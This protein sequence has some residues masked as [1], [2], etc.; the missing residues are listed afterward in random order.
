MMQLFVSD[1]SFLQHLQQD[2][3]QRGTV[4]FYLDG[5]Q[6]DNKDDLLKEIATVTQFPEDF[7]SNWDALYD[8]LTD[9]S[10]CDASEYLFIYDNAQILAHA[11]PEDWHTFCAILRDTVTYWQD[12]ATPLNV[13]IAG[14]DVTDSLQTI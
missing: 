6:I 5:S 9:L 1:P 10:W 3:R 4:V 8:Y 2:A 14:A 13:V 7:G 11:A 12:S